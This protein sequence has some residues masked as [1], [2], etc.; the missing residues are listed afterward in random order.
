MNILQCIILNTNS[1]RIT[2]N[3]LKYVLD[4][5]PQTTHSHISY[6][7]HNQHGLANQPHKTGKSFRF[8]LEQHHLWMLVIRKAQH[9]ILF[10]C[11]WNKRVAK[12]G[13]FCACAQ[14]QLDVET[15]LPSSPNC[16]APTLKLKPTE[17]CEIRTGNCVLL[18]C[19]ARCW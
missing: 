12:K 18:I 11:Q 15:A 10:R 17:S 1:L 16:Q 8:W 9:S 3:S 2:T 4:P 6:C 7:I 13:S 5:F 19:R 14:H